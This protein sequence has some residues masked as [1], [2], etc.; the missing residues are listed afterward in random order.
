MLLPLM[1]YPF[2]QPISS[3]IHII[4]FVFITFLAFVLTFWLNYQLEG[5]F[6]NSKRI[7]E[8][9]KMQVEVVTIQTSRAIKREDPE[10]FGVAY[11]IAVFHNNQHKT[12]FLWGQYLDELETEQLFPNTT[13]TFV[14]PLHSS[15]SDEFIDFKVVG[16]YFEPE[17]ILPAFTRDV[18]KGGAYP[19]NGQLLDR[20]IDEINE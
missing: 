14:R 20:A 10:D 19:M 5:S 8:I 6:S 18:F 4:Y 12:L 16:N 7:D 13:F 17:R 11:Y 9:R 15:T 2:I 1:F 3:N